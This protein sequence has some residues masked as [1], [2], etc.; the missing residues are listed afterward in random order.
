[1]DREV[2]RIAKLLR[3]IGSDIDA[4]AKLL[5][6]AAEYL[7]DREPLPDALADYLARA[8]RHATAIV[9]ADAG[10]RVEDARIARLAHALG[11]TRNEGRPRAD[12]SKFDVALTVLVHG[13]D[14]SETEMA[15]VLAETY[16]VSRST[17]RTRI[18][19]AKAKIAEGRELLGRI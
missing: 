5:A 15:K 6:I 12:V 3:R 17:A 19:E 9:E 14:V 8:F 4:P 16:G 11:M 13:D 2:A 1:M 7:K 10:Q 18:K